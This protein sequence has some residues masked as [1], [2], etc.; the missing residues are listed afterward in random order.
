MYL[1]GRWHLVSVES[2]ASAPDPVARLDV[3]LLGERVLGPLLGIADP[4][5]DPRID[6]VGG[7]RG[8]ESSSGASIRASTR[9]PSRS[10]RRRWTR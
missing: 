8:P 6:F 10:T 2:G 7:I 4:R 1:A 9:W 3:S 5:T